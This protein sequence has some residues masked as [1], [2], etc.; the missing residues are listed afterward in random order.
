MKT[1]H[2]L[3]VHTLVLDKGESPEPHFPDNIVYRSHHDSDKYLDE[4]LKEI[5]KIDFKKEN[6]VIFYVDPFRRKVKCDAMY[7][8]LE[9]LSG[10]T[11]DQIKG[12][13]QKEKIVFSRQLFHYG[14]MEAKLG[15]TISAGF[16]TNNDHATV[17]HSCGVIN[18]CLELGN[19]WRKN[20]CLEF[21]GEL[22]II[23]NNHKQK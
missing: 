10:I 12:K 5:I 11:K 3:T 20:L 8:V 18:N 13:S 9:R 6:L 14:F 7:E 16:E 1:K 15:S 4:H 21:I 19:G 23:I 17:L 2:I 22:D